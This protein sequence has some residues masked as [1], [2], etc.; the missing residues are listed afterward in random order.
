MSTIT[1][2]PLYHKA[3][4]IRRALAL[5]GFTFYDNGE[6]KELLETASLFELFHEP[7]EIKA[8]QILT[9]DGSYSLRTQL[10]PMHLTS[11]G[12]ALPLKAAVSGR[13][14]DGRDEKNP[15]HLRIEGVIA[16]EGMTLTDLNVLW[17]KIAAGIYGVGASVSLDPAGRDC[18]SV[19]VKI[20]TNEARCLGYIGQAVWIAR[21]LLGLEDKSIPVWVFTIDVDSIAAA[22]LGLASRDDLYDNRMSFIGSVEDSAPSF[23]NSFAVKTVDVLRSLGY[24]EYI[25]DKFYT[26][27]A[28]K[29]MNMIQD[30]WDTNNQGVP[31]VKPLPYNNPLTDCTTRDGLP[32][33]LAPALEQALS[34]NFTA[35]VESLRIFELS[36]IFKPGKDGGEPWEVMSLSFGAYA[37]GLD[38]KSFLGEVTAVLRK[39]GITNSFFI[40]TNMAIAYRTDQCMVILDEKMKYLDGNCGHISPTALD[41]FKISTDAYMAQ[42]ELP[43]LDWKADQEYGFVPYEL[44]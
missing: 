1:R 35:G 29:R 5:N 25:G 36:H 22:D 34:D 30:A 28:Y 40:P 15:Q 16:D 38:Y 7:E 11:F 6:S 13:I 43:T 20:S 4:K 33:V 8:G 2:H 32:T 42:F 39:M 24:T 37:P 21:A 26:S 41:N 19:N 9:G 12:K 44:R 23:G 3:D 14:Y 10:L 17:G 27:D 31:L 18:M